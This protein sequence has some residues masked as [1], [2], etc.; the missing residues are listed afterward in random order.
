[1]NLM[2]VND[3]QCGQEAITGCTVSTRIG[4]LSYAELSA[5]SY[6]EMKACSGYVKPGTA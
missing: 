2:C 5:L 6:N 4:L 3:G 1:M